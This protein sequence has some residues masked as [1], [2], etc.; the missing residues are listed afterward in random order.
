MTYIFQIFKKL[1]ALNSFWRITGTHSKIEISL[2]KK[3][4]SNFL[5]WHIC[6]FRVVVIIPNR[7]ILALSRDKF[8]EN[9]LRDFSERVVQIQLCTCIKSLRDYLFQ[10]I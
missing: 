4:I 10:H 1:Q 6:F 5:P 7:D 3:V 2:R 8:V 9:S